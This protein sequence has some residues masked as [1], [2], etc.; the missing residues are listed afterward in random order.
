MANF[1]YE[2]N[3]TIGTASKGVI[4]VN[5]GQLS[6]IA[7]VDLFKFTLTESTLLGFGFTLPTGTTS[8]YFT[9]R[10]LDDSGNSLFS[11]NAGAD[12]SNISFSLSAGD[13]FVKVS[14]NLAYLNLDTTPITG[15]FFTDQY[16]FAM[17][18]LPYVTATG[19]IEA[20]NVAASA[21]EIIFGNGTPL[22]DLID[23]PVVIG[24]LS[25]AID[26]D[27]FKFSIDQSQIGQYSFK[28]TAPSNG[29]PDVVDPTIELP[30]TIKEFFKISILD[31]NENV[32]ISHYVSG[33]PITGYSFDFNANVVGQYFVK[34]E[35]GGSTVSINTMQYSFE[36]NSEDPSVEKSNLISGG[37]G[38]NY[39]LGTSTSDFIRGFAGKDVL[40]GMAGND[41]LD[42][43]VGADTMKGGSGNDIYT[44]D[45]KSDS[46]IENLG[47][48]MDRVIT[49]ID[50]TLVK[51]V[52]NLVLDQ[53]TLNA[54]GKFDGAIKGTGNTLDNII[55]GNQLANTLKGLAGNDTLD[56][57]LGGKDKLEGGLG[58]DTYYINNVLDTI[59]EESGEGTD[60]V[61]AK[62]DVF[63]LVA[64]V[65]NLKLLEVGTAEDGR[66]IASFGVGNA[67]AN[68]IEGSSE[69]NQL[70][71]LA[72]DDNIYGLSGND[73][74][75]GGAGN[76]FL[77]GGLGSDYFIFDDTAL[78]ST[79]N[80]DIIADFESGVDAIQL[81]TTIFKK[82]VAGDNDN[83][84]G[85][86]SV[87]HFKV[88][89]VATGANDYIIYNQD[90]G[91]LYYDADG[92]GSQA[93]VLFANLIGGQNLA[94]TD[95]TVL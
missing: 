43:G 42:G 88:G 33:V 74:L 52:E 93:A 6:S 10:F 45:N 56:G 24:S 85:E 47:G 19:E 23:V 77:V 12:L 26:K 46:V 94:Y 78:N 13:Y 41:S 3:G 80:V 67:L 66:P 54:K 89:A 11:T 84:D 20:N 21:T 34:I 87:D 68:T 28:F 91:N 30:S 39:L 17:T 70:S 61:L 63:G 44:V 22:V 5:S 29:A 79:T 50:Y 16:S 90:T 31:A 38:N 14:A 1:E 95:F 25:S 15:K 69:V 59:T 48:G 83:F 9:I 55:V 49:K 18:T 36:I 73:A 57:G 60:T 35:N 64:N 72:G 4:G 86:L 82:L 62:L 2:S 76:D 92:N 32:L 58:N 75:I 7:D 81:S 65:E 71:G 37:I 40:S 53:A 8:D 51:N 27:Y